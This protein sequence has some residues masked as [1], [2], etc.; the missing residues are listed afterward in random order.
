MHQPFT[1]RRARL[2]ALKAGLPAKIVG[3]HGTCRTRPVF[4]HHAAHEAA[5]TVARYQRRTSRC[6][7]QL[8]PD[9]AARAP[10]TA[11]RSSPPV[12]R[13]RPAP[14]PPQRLHCRLSSSYGP[15]ARKTAAA[16]H[17]RH[18]AA[19]D[20]L[21]DRLAAGARPHSPKAP[22]LDA[23]TTGVGALGGGG[24]DDDDNDDARFYRK[25]AAQK[26]CHSA[27]PTAARAFLAGAGAFAPRGT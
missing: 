7:L 20:R 13:W 23:T 1:G 11:Q 14:A 16:A 3:V 5:R 27:P 15:H 25:A 24:D 19:P 6:A 21:G 22:G 17:V 18:R 8:R 12:P 4:L 9:P 2:V 10:P 26:S